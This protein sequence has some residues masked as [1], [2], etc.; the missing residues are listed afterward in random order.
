MFVECVYIKWEQ[1]HRAL[2]T[3]INNYKNV[4]QVKMTSNSKQNRQ[5][6]RTLKDEKLHF[7]LKNKKKCYFNCTFFDKSSVVMLQCIFYMT[8][9]GRNAKT[10]LFWKKAQ[11]N[12]G[13]LFSTETS[14][15]TWDIKLLLCIITKNLFLCYAS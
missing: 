6:H 4:T 1:N 7:F 9:R 13:S 11:F 2:G 14:T 8:E 10:V 5:K 15:R 12:L 3:H